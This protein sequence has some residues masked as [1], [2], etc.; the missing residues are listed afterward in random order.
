MT[1]RAPIGSTGARATFVALV[2]S[3]AFAAAAQAQ[4]AGGEFV[5]NSYTTGDQYRAAVAAAPSGDFVVVW[6]S[7]GSPGNDTSQ[8][9]VQGQRFG[10]DGSLLGVQFQINTYTH[11]SQSNPSVAV[12]ADGD[13][14]AAWSSFGSSGTDT[15]VYSVQAQRYAS[16]GSSRGGQF[17]VNTY[18]TQTQA[19]AAVAAAADGRFVVVWQSEGADFQ[20][21]SIRGQRY[22]AN[23]AQLGSEFPVNTFWQGEQGAPSVDAA[24]DG[25][26]VVAWSSRG[27]YGTDD[28]NT[29]SI[30]GQRFASDGSKRG[31]EFQVNTYTTF[32]QFAPDVAMDA[33]GGFVV[34]W[35]NDW[36]SWGTD[37]SGKSVQ[38]Q[39]YASDGA[40]RGEQFQVNTGTALDEQ[41][42]VVAAEADGDFV[43]LWEKKY[44]SSLGSTI[45]GQRFS[46]IGLPF[47]PEFQVDSVSYAPQHHPAVAAT[48]AGDFVAVWDRQ[49]PYA[50][51]DTHLLGV[52]GQRF[53]LFDVLAVPALSLGAIAGLAGAL[54]MLGASLLRRRRTPVA[55]STR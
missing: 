1:T 34:V 15:Q 51:G 26:F 10:S 38:A 50:P 42:P 54:L 43:V 19:S 3:L 55:G 7:G 52:F 39:R 22:D 23:G 25:S 46:R 24:A 49:D 37:T 45:H 31:A 41:F 6:I 53:D 18:T 16:D 30:Q 47:G 28:Y 40:P 35:H 2:C 11:L 27:G 32:H 8:S 13:I 14:V 12:D 33:D 48:V 21:G 9:S 29:Y 5:I 20:G 17:Q 44:P 36:G 4:T